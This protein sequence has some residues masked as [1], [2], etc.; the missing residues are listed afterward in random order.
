MYTYVSVLL[1]FINVQFWIVGGQDD[2]ANAWEDAKLLYGQ[3]YNH[4]YNEG[5]PLTDVLPV[6]GSVPVY[7]YMAMK[8]TSLNGFDAVAGQID[9]AGSMSMS[10]MDIIQPPIRGKSE[11]ILGTVLIDY[12]NAWSPRVVLTNA[13]DTVKDIADTTY[14]L[15]YTFS[16]VASGNYTA[17]VTWE[18]RVLLRASCE[19]DVTF[20]PFDRQVCDVTYT[21]WAYTKDEVKLIVPTSE[22]DTSAAE[23]NGVWK[24]ISTESEAFVSNDAYNVRFRIT[25]QREPLYFTFNIGLP[26]LLLGLLNGFVFLLPAESGERIGFCITCFLSFIV[27]MQTTMSFLP[28]LANPMSLLCIYVFLMMCFS[29]FI[30]IT[31]IFMLRI[32]HMPEGTKVPNWMQMIVRVI[33]CK[34]CR[35]CDKDKSMPLPEVEWPEVGRMLDFF[36]FLAFIAAQTTLT[37][38]F[39][40]PLATRF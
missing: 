7:V 39:L 15:R 1:L 36:F 5:T 6:Q 4:Y 17:N 32:Y 38:F 14:K 23:G 2:T 21:A 20:Y 31:C 12:E 16:E 37:I 34:V 25:I 35:C 33:G 40:L 30:N 8:L 18:P 26:I 9:I 11:V 29:V 10:W 3:I 19:P 22:W 27:L 13:V 24:I 28:E